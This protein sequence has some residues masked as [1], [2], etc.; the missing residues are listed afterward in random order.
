MTAPI[1]QYQNFLVGLASLA[2]GRMT[3]SYRW[4]VDEAKQSHAALVLLY[5]AGERLGALRESIAR[6]EGS[7]CRDEDRA[8]RPVDIIDAHIFLQ[9]LRSEGLAPFPAEDPASFRQRFQNITHTLPSVPF[10]VRLSKSSLSQVRGTGERGGPVTLPPLASSLTSPD[11]RLLI[12]ETALGQEEVVIPSRYILREEIGD[13]GEA[14]VYRAFEEVLEREVAIKVATIS[15]SEERARIEQRFK[16]GARLQARPKFGRIAE[17]FGTGIT[18]TR[19]PFL[20]MK[21]YPEKTLRQVIESLH[22]GREPF[23]VEKAIA[24]A[25]QA[26]EAVVWAHQKIGVIHRDIKP[27]NFLRGDQQGWLE[28]SDFGIARAADGSGRQESSGK[29]DGTFG[30]IAPE[31]LLGEEIESYHQIDIFALGVTL[32]EIFTGQKPYVFSFA[33]HVVRQAATML[34]QEPVLP[35]QLRPGLGI[36]PALDA[37]LM[38]ALER[39]RTRRYQDVGE[40]FFDL[41]LLKSRNFEDQAA[42]EK[43][44]ERWRERMRDAIVAAQEALRRFPDVERIKAKIADLSLQLYNDAFETGDG[45]QM[46]VSASTINKVAPHSPPAAIVNRTEKFR[47]TLDGPVPEGAG[48][49]FALFKGARGDDGDI[50]YQKLMDLPWDALRDTARFQELPRG[51]YAITMRDAS[52]LVKGLTVPL[53]PWPMDEVYDIRLPVY[54]KNLFRPGDLLIPAGP[55]VIRNSRGSHLEKPRRI[56]MTR[57]DLRVSSFAENGDYLHFLRLVRQ[58]EGSD[59]AFRLKPQNWDPKIVERIVQGQPVTERDLTD[60]QGRPLDPTVPVSYISA[61]QGLKFMKE[62]IAPQAR[63]L[64]PD[65]HKRFSR[66]NDSRTFPHGDAA[67]K[68]GTYNWRITGHMAPGKVL[69]NHARGIRDLSPFC[70]LDDDG[71]PKAQAPWVQSNVKTFLTNDDPERF[72]PF[73]DVPLAEADRFT[74]VAGL[75]FDDNVPDNVEILRAVGTDDPGVFGIRA[76]VPLREAAPTPDLSK[77]LSTQKK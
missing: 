18:A 35:S 55:V 52:E 50:R 7:L 33:D 69:S 39:D 71:I 48:L 17:V 6:L 12:I 40:M 43:D 9:S 30:Y 36:T 67:P 1:A 61:S 51:L 22:S 28:L 37:I 2:D 72:L 45:R 62:M 5:G 74:L 60:V 38:K 56:Q 23:D 3:A 20:V 41:A 59:A 27:E 21:Y 75:G 19:Q 25:L 58:L 57:F 63:Y 13:G 24:F 10:A 47:F 64:T 31:V 11:G 14:K 34:R 54:A 53:P 76:A 29:P 49:A 68:G 65:E 32:Y 66:G 70:L 42:G 26:V 44:V 77:L 46:K 4:L 16:N 8:D 73:V 15:D